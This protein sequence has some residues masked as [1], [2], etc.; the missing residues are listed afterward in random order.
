MDNVKN[1]PVNNFRVFTCVITSFD[2]Q[3]ASDTL[4]MTDFVYMCQSCAAV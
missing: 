3:S 1:L 4:V 2:S